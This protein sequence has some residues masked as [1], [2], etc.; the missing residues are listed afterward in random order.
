M[1]SWSSYFGELSRNLSSLKW[2]NSPE[3]DLILLNIG[4]LEFL[5]ERGSRAPIKI[6][7]APS[8]QPS[9]ERTLAHITLTK[10]LKRHFEFKRSKKKESSFEAD[11]NS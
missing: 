10:N 3:G 2:L 1:E 6:K 8:G 7:L 5:G 11:P 4:C 9:K